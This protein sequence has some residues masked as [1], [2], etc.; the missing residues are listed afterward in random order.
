MFRVW[1]KIKKFLV[2]VLTFLVMFNQ[3]LPVL[4]M[5]EGELPAPS[6]SPVTVVETGDAAAR[7][8]SENQTNTTAINGNIDTVMVPVTENSPEVIDPFPEPSPTPVPSIELSPSPESI[9]ATDS[10]T[11]VGPSPSPNVTEIVINNQAT[12]ETTTEASAET[13]DN[14][15]VGGETTMAT[16]DSLALSSSI[17]LVNTTLIDATL[18]V[19]VIAI[20]SEWNGDIL[21]DPMMG[22][23]S[24]TSS[25][26]TPGNI[27]ITNSNTT[28]A[29]TTEAVA[30]TGDNLQVAS[31]SGELT[32]GAAVAIAENNALVNT[33]VVGADI[34]T[35]LAENLWLWSGKILN[36]ESPGSVSPASA[37]SNASSLT[38]QEGCQETCS[39]DVTID[40]QADVTTTTIATASTG[41]NTQIASGSAMM[42]TGSAVAAAVATTMVNTTLINARYRQLSLLMLAPWS[43]NLVFKYPDLLVSAEA[44]S[45]VY[46]GEE[47]TYTVR[48][49]N[50]GYGRAM[51]VDWLHN[52][53]NQTEIIEENKERVGELESGATMTRTLQ[54]ASDGWAGQTITLTAMAT[55]GNSE[56]S[57]TNNMAVVQT[58]VI[59]RTSD[60]P[61]ADEAENNPEE[62]PKLRLSSQNNIHEFVMPGDGVTYDMEA[63]NDGP[64]GAKNVVLIQDFYAPDATFIS[65]FQGR[66]GELALNQR[67]TIRF[68]LQTGSS[69]KPGEYY[70]ESHLWGESDQGAG[71]TSNTVHNSLS[72]R[73]RAV[74]EIETMTNARAA[75]ALSPE[76]EQ[77]LGAAIGTTNC[78][79]CVAFP[80]Y[81]AITLGSLAYYLMTSRRSDY[82][83]AVRW[84]LPLPLAAYGGLIWSNPG[85]S[86]GLIMLPSSTSACQL[87]LPFAFLI[88]LGIMFGA[89]KLKKIGVYFTQKNLNIS[90]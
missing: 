69:L 53:T 14:V 77:I 88:Y 34:F 30:N 24:L 8:V 58:K 49:K 78:R 55:S 9:I 90:R 22:A 64:V 87:F 67:R 84:G 26:A 17:T 39:L 60:A 10:A 35:L 45:E 70:T 28:V 32:T 4:V 7:A 36:W 40:N 54:L 56:E 37:I 12:T 31:G 29:T 20:L 73:A 61:S 43:G 3:F 68:V 44:P 13:G 62:V 15:Q 18:Q 86:N 63:Y 42:T 80:W 2:I 82:G 52:I 16:G 19:G 81:V 76:Q 33:T 38:N 79:D 5:A 50:R 59:A 48:V 74:A 46:E 89:Q 85:C 83:R 71:T 25:R 23:G 11:D 1:K 75:A 41:G 47:I 65:R 21:L 57:I 72:L 27:D 51:G 66:V 6:A